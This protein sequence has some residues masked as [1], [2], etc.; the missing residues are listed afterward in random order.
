[1]EHDFR[2][3]IMGRLNYY[4][5]FCMIAYGE[6]I[7]TSEFLAKNDWKIIDNCMNFLS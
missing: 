1:M 7:L 5:T 2:G 3:K 6:E 4:E